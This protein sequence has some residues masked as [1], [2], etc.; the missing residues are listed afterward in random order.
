VIEVDWGQHRPPTCFK[1]GKRG[2]IAHNCWGR[3]EQVQMMTREEWQKLEDE[4]RQKRE[5]E[6]MDSNLKD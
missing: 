6:E 1:C 5:K 2:H 4:E 3:V